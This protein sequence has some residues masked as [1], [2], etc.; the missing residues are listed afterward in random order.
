MSTEEQPPAKKAKMDEE[1]AP[2]ASEEDAPP[3]SEPTGWEDHTMNI[4]EAV[5]KDDET[6]HLSA[7]K[8]APVQTLQ[9]IGKVA[10]EAFAGLGIETVD[11]LGQYKFFR[12]ARA[13]AALAE[14][15][16]A[17]GRLPGS[18]M[19]VDDAVDKEW[20]AKSLTEILDAPTEAL[21]GIGKEA[22]ELL[23]SLGI[24]TVGDLA[25]CKYCRWAEAITT[26]AGYEELKTKKECKM[27]AAMRRLS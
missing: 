5:M 9:G 19:N 7:L 14:T 15:E 27:D 21:Q 13:L 3:T 23:E 20:E 8:D 18:V 22:C 12:M 24:K 4:S 6:K 16:T 1:D 11:A 2:P 25:K 10:A 17:G 26:M